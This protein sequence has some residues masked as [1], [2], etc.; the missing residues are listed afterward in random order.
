MCQSIQYQLSRSLEYFSSDVNADVTMSE[1]L[2]SGT[3]IIFLGKTWGERK[4]LWWST[5][6]K[7]KMKEN[8]LN[9]WKRSS[10][11]LLEK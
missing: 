6:R 4:S 5:E 1:L 10:I 3:A 11:S 9:E 7:W 2:Q 8:L